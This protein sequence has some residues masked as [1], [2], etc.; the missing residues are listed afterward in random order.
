MKNDVYLITTTLATLWAFNCQGGIGKALLSHAQ[1]ARIAFDDES[2]K[3]AK[4][5]VKSKTFEVN[6]N[7]FNLKHPIGCTRASNVQKVLD[8]YLSKL[9][10]EKFEIKG[11]LTRVENPYDVDYL[12]ASDEFE[13]CKDMRDALDKS[14]LE[15]LT[16]AFQK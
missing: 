11:A 14:W 4:T 13:Y 10:Q 5:A 3:I 15:A 6:W 8:L 1:G 2:F 12:R 7:Q 16:R 9:I